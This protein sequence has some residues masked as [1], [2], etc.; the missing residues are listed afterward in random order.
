MKIRL[1]AALLLLFSYPAFAQQL[2]V[3][4]EKDSPVYA[5]GEP[6]AWKLQVSGEGAEGVTEV[7]YNVKRDAQTVLSSGV[8]ALQQGTARLESH[9]DAPGTLL[10]D[11]TFDKV[12]KET[13]RISV[14]A[15]VEPF[16]IEP[17]MPEPADFETFWKSKVEELEQVPAN[18][19]LSS[20]PSGSPD[21]DYWKFTLDN[22]RGSHVQGQLARPK[23]GEKFPALLRLQYAG[24]YGL[25]KGNVVNWANGGW[26]TLN[27]NAHDLPIDQPA[28]F[29]TTQS[30]GPLKNYVAIGNDNRESSYFLR[31]ILSCYRAIDYLKTRPD[32]DGKTLVVEGTSQGGMQSLM[33]GGLNPTVTA[34]I[35][36]VPAGCDT[37]GPVLGRASPWPYWAGMAKGNLQIL[38][39]SRY[40]DALNFARHIKVPTL[41]AVGLLDLT[42]TAPGVIATFNQITSPSKRLVIMPR[43][44]HKGSGGTQADYPKNLSLWLKALSKGETPPLS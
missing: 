20:E 7:H 6:V 8:L 4:P 37:S 21:S 28:D 25:S 30:Q 39:T 32:W 22:I 31:M 11:F 10:V 24:V 3:T 1:C 35:V 2:T 38:E 42:A 13:V 29:Y 5:I 17:A 34:V 18:P 41:V 40:F 16:K 23:V 36:N 15:V 19:V 14:G 43:S 26:L 33:M 44:D 9:L 12:N 27:I